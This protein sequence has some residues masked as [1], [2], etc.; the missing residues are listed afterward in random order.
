MIRV[1]ND[2][3]ADT[4]NGRAGQE[5]LTGL[6]SDREVLGFLC[7]IPIQRQFDR[8]TEACWQLT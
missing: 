2:D 8:S 6:L 5:S 3:M 7:T 4:T 1:N